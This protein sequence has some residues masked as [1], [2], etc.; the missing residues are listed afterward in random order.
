MDFCSQR[1][2]ERIPRPEAR[3]M[4]MGC[5]GRG[6]GKPHKCTPCLA[7]VTSISGCSPCGHFLCLLSRFAAEGPP[8]H[9]C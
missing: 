1:E 8:G 5:R 3:D 6:A 2:V 9:G 4:N 7:R